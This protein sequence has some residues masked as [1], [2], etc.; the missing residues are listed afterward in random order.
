[1]RGNDEGQP[2]SDHF[3]KVKSEILRRTAKN[4]GPTTGDLLEAIEGSNEDFDDGINAVTLLLAD[5]VKEDK[6]RAKA[7]SAMCAE[8]HRKLINEEFT[9][10]HASDRV[11]DATTR[12]ELVEQAAVRAANLVAETAK[13]AAGVRVHAAED[14]ATVL[15]DAASE[16]P[17]RFTKEQIVA[18]FWYLVALLA[19]S[20]IVSGLF[21]RL[22]KSL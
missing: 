4:G 5:H 7:Q 6:A 2:M 21:D 8:T 14:A 11:D 13:K 19:I 18:N 12:A 22:M 15:V 3:E 17:K 16:A 9:S 1:M 20:G 10:Q